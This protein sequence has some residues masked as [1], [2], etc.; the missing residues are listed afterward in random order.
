MPWMQRAHGGDKTRGAK[1]RAGRGKLLKCSGDNHL[2]GLFII[3]LRPSSPG[4]G[5]EPGLS[6]AA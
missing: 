3:F 6:R 5:G 2:A 1:G 4:Q